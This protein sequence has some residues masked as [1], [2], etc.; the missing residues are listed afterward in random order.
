M[1]EIQ[2]SMGL[3]KVKLKEANKPDKATVRNTKE[4]YHS[5]VTKRC[6]GI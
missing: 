1:V 3:S 5:K 4:A 6:D 2:T